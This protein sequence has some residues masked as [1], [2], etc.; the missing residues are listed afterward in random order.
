MGTIPAEV[1]YLR[2]SAEKDRYWASRL[3]KRS[4]PRIG[5]AWSG[6]TVF[7]NDQNRS[8]SLDLLL[9]LFELPFEFHV[10]QKEV[11]ESDEAI[12]ARQANLFFHGEQLFD[13]SDTASLISEMDLVISVDT[14]VAHLAGALN[15]PL[16]VLLPFAPDF[17]W[18]LGRVDSPWYPSARLFRQS[19]RMDWASVI[20]D[21]KLALLQQDW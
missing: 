9:P 2:S 14:S 11:R 5:L 13:F 20:S 4:I 15:C 3:G 1:P 16:W 12:L 8:L 21:V 7:R 10:I 19:Q 6:G 17:R 18:L